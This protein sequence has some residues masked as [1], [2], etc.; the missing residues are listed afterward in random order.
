MLRYLILC[1]ALLFL[2]HAAKGV[3]DTL[4]FHYDASVFATLGNDQYWN[5]EISWENKW[6]KA[7]DGKLVRPLTERFGASST[8]LVGLTDGWHLFQDIQYWCIRLA[9][10]LLLFQLL[11]PRYRKAWI[12]AFMLALLYILQSVAFHLTYTLIS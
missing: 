7:P 3:C 9:V 11:V 12:F 1:A 4:Q 10:T 8:V 6:E 2:A 5:P